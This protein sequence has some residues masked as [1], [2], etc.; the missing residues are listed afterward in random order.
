MPAQDVCGEFTSSQLT[1]VFIV[2]G[3]YAFGYA[4]LNLARFNN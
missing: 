3:K 1:A 4:L 2:N